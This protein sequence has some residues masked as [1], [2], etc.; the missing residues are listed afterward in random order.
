MLTQGEIVG[1]LVQR[2]LISPQEI[3]DGELIVRD[4]SRRN[5]N[6]SVEARNGTSYFV[7]QGL[8][9]GGASAVRHESE[10]YRYLAALGD[11]FSARLPCLRDYDP[12]H[13]VLILELVPD[14]EDLRARQLRLNCFPEQLG[15][16]LGESLGTLHRLTSTEYGLHSPTTAPWV[17]SVHRPDLSILRE[18]SAANL[19]L[20]KIVQS[21]PGFGESL[22]QLG[23][24]WRQAALLHHDARWENYLVARAWDGQQA[25]PLKMVDW[26][27]ATRGDPGWDVGSVLS[28]F[29][30]AWIHSMAISGGEPPDQLTELAALPLDEMKPAISSCWEA[31]V[32]SARLHSSEANDRLLRAVRYAAARLVQTAFESM[33]TSSRR[34][35]S[36]VLHLQVSANMLQRPFEAIGFLGLR[37]NGRFVR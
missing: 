11:E 28:Q 20:I 18:V 17:C 26:E 34:T 24:G 37:L 10:S 33:Q 31:Y 2:R 30:S 19:E 1:Y 36:A 32:D 21:T 12:Q 25:A 16:A 3:V 27:I 22:D 23:A 5:L 13:N 15:A 14:A 8:G 7:K 9:V 4:A 29:L 6:F 35:S